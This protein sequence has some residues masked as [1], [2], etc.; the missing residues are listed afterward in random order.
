MDRA[1]LARQAV[2]SRA[3]HPVPSAIRTF[4]PAKHLPGRKAKLQIQLVR[5][6]LDAESVQSVPSGSKSR[7]SLSERTSIPR[8]SA[9]ASL[10]PAP[11][12]ATTTVVSLLTLPAALPPS[13]A[14]TP[15]A[16]SRVNRS[17]LPVNT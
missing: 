3:V 17:N 2:P 6:N 8:L 9:L 16:A 10:E 14:T 5:G 11:G 1:V 12:P 4:E 15:S 13:R 7:N